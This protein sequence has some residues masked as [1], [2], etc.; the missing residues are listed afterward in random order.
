MSTNANH[1]PYTACQVADFILRKGLA[2]GINDLGNRKLNKLVYIVHGWHL[3]YL[4]SPLVSDAVE[5]WKY[6]P[7]FSE[8]YYWTKFKVKENPEDNEAITEQDFFVD[9]INS[10]IAKN[11]S[12]SC[13][14]I[15]HV[16]DIYFAESATALVNRTHIKGTPWWLAQ[17]SGFGVI[18]NE[19]IQEYYEKRFAATTN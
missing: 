17:M 1:P 14:L 15:E 4:N 12:E 9:I 18:P 11:N 6:G 8:L 10:R 3:G 7:A 16:C 13:Q 2:Q 5:V 19:L